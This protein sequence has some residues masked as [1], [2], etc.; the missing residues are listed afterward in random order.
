M[1]LFLHLFYNVFI[2]RVSMYMHTY[3]CIYI[4][5][6]QSYTYTRVHACVCELKCVKTAHMEI[7]E[8]LE[9][10]GPFLPLCWPQELN[11]DCQSW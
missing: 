5:V 8:Q 11:S 6:Y 3:V 4:H 2:Y 7:R 10:V 1:F 9:G